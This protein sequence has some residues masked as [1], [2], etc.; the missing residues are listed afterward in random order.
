LL[1]LGKQWRQLYKPFDKLKKTHPYPGKLRSA[2][3]QERTPSDIRRIDNPTKQI[4]DIQKLI[5]RRILRKVALPRFMFGAVAGKTLSEHAQTHLAHQ[6]ENLVTMDIS[7]YYPSINCFQ[8][9]FVWHSI[10]GFSPAVS[11]ILTQLTTYEWRLPQGAPTSPAL[12]NIY[13]ASIY[14]PICMF[15]DARD[16]KVSTWVDDLVFSGKHAKS[17]RGLVIRTL[18]SHGLVINQ[19]KNKVF[20]PS[21]EKVVTGVRLGARN[22][23]VPHKTMSELRAAVHRLTSG[24][25][26]E[27]GLERYRTN[28][29]ARI[30]F[31]GTINRRDADKIKRMVKAAKVKL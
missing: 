1:D 10:L 6:T 12:A 24:E 22:V 2:K 9:Y 29:A 13:L 26:P 18:K 21:S 4:K 31:L 5:L 7:S 8:V 11:A 15:A 27:A 20:D 23:R 16:V 14:G 30:A 28:L 3:M 25:V 17:V 19:N